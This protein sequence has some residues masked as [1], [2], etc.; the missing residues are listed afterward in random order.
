M[1]FG[2][3]GGAGIEIDMSYPIIPEFGV[4]YKTAGVRWS[5][6]YGESSGNYGYHGETTRT[7]RGSV[8]DIFGK[9]KINIPIGDFY[10]RPYFGYAPSILLTAEVETH[11]EGWENNEYDG[12][13]EWN[14]TKVEDVKDECNRLDHTLLFGLEFIIANSFIVGFEYERGLLAWPKDYTEDG[15]TYYA[16]KLN[17]GYKF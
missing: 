14:S 6:S 1:V 8:L 2:F 5:I 12:Y 7:N 15:L 13:H 17:L 11:Q 10:M 16:Y 9:L 3:S 4:R